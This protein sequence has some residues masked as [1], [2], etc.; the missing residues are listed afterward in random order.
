MANE[1]DLI[2]Q[3]RVN[4]SPNLIFDTGLIRQQIDVSGGDHAFITVDVLVAGTQIIP[5]GAV[6]TVGWIGIKNHDPT[7]FVDVRGNAGS[8]PP[9]KILAGE[10]VWFRAAANLIKLFADTATVKC[11][12]W[13]FE[14]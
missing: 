11:E 1:M 4:R 5:S 8:D 14:E 10:T 9:M 6:G 2:Q 13:I 12:I 3:V 7:N